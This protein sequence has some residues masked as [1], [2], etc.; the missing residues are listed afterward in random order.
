MF[1]FRHLVYNFHSHFMVIFLLCSCNWYYIYYYHILFAFLS[2]H[3]ICLSLASY[4]YHTYQIVLYNY[5]YFITQLLQVNPKKI[6][7]IKNIVFNIILIN[8]PN[9]HNNV[10]Y[11]SSTYCLFSY[12]LNVVFQNTKNLY[13]LCFNYVWYKIYHLN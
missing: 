7:I 11:R 10:E 8:H 12:I 3:Y 6:W 5:Y 9:S 13:H 4:W 1:P 2:D